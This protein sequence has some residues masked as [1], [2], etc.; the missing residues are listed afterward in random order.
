MT[1]QEIRDRIALYSPADQARMLTNEY[2]YDLPES[3]FASLMAEILSHMRM[4]ESTQ[5]RH[6]PQVLCE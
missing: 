3:D 5:G 1:I 4:A 6:G 2:R